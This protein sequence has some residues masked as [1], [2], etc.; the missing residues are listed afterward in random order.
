MKRDAMV[1]GFFQC[2]SNVC[3]MGLMGTVFWYAIWLANEGHIG[4]TEAMGPMF[5]IT[6]AMVRFM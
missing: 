1:Q 5:V 3:L 6:G 2:L 4:F